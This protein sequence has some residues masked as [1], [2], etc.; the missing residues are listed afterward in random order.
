MH[1]G[2][3]KKRDRFL[4]LDTDGRTSTKTRV[5]SCALLVTSSKTA[6]WG[7]WV[8]R[9]LVITPAAVHHPKFLKRA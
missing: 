7:V 1:D 2:I 6:A 5:T 8:P 9:G 3:G 4:L